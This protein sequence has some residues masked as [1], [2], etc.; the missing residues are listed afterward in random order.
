MQEFLHIP[1]LLND[2]V[3]SFKLDSG[4]M[5][6]DATLGGGGHA[7]EILK[8]FPQIKAY[9]GVD[10]DAEALS[11]AKINLKDFKQV[12]YEHSNY[13][14]AI[15]KFEDNTFA[16]ILADIGVSSYQIDNSERGFSFL[17]DGPL[18]MRMNKDNNFSAMDVVNG[19]SEKELADVI[20]N[21]GEE[22]D[23]RRIAACIVKSRQKQKITTTSQL[24][25][26]VASCSHKNPASAVQRTFQA[27]RIEVNDEL[28]VLKR[29][30]EKAFKK[31]R[32]GGRLAIISFH[33]LEDRIVK[34]AFQE[35]A[36]GC[37][38]PPSFPVCVCGHKPEG[39]LVNKK[40]IVATESELL[41]NKRSASAK[42]RVIEKL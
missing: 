35:F 31:L 20:Y 26:I 18:D 42:L 36:R 12:E 15:D 5:F 14:T 25:K 24:Q 37:I 28:G 2:V 1:V 11:A 39:K 22:R 21:Y 10:Q 8:K 23:S 4:D 19:Y 30:I 6:F 32:K 29:F 13:E 41:Q 38:C 3:N 9:V 33:S 16:G 7:K 27:I 34:Q 17:H 40:P